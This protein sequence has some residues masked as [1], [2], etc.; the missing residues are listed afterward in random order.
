MAVVISGES[1]AGKTVNAHHFLQFVASMA[2]KSKEVQR[3]KTQLLE[4]NPLLEAFGNAKT[5]RNDNSSRF[6]KLMSILFK[7][8][9]PTGGKIQV[10][11]LEKARV[12][13]QLDGERNF[14]AFYQLLAGADSSLKSKLQLDSAK[15]YRYTKMC[16]SVKNMDDGREF[17]DTVKAMEWCGLDDEQQRDVWRVVAAVL[18]IGNIEFVVSNRNRQQHC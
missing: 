2:S 11:L 8:G 4:T 9:D 16:T 17:Q 5:I 13:H 6:G 14:H 7:Y 1:G 18:H 10:Y 15:D 3:I 12:V